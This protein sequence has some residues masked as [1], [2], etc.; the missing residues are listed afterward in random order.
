MAIGLVCLSGGIGFIATLAGYLGTENG[1][2]LLGFEKRP[3]RL[4]PLLGGYIESL[5]PDATF[6]QVFAFVFSIVLAVAYYVIFHCIFRIAALHR[7]GQTYRDAGDVVRAHAA[8]RQ[9]VSP[10]I[11][12]GVLF[13]FIGLCLVFDLD[14]FLFRI[15]YG[16]VGTE[17]SAVVEW[18]RNFAEHHHLFAWHLADWSRWAYAALTI[19]AC[20]MVEFSGRQLRDDW[21]ELW[22]SVEQIVSYLSGRPPTARGTVLPRGLAPTTSAPSR[23]APT[24]A[25]PASPSP[26]ATAPARPVRTSASLPVPAPAAESAAAGG[27]A[28]TDRPSPGTSGPQEVIGGAPGERV[29]MAAAVADPDRYYVDR[30]RRRIYARAFWNQIT[31]P[32]SP[33]SP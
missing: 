17:P 6:P 2:E 5:A 4:D 18:N 26:T 9:M 33:A 15:T 1:L 19:I 31:A 8:R 13:A 29:T 14:L 27:T 20:L 16:L 30:A 28:A 24:T 11:M 21:Y 12:S 22:N 3:L 23:P 7:D 10:A 32:R 25:S